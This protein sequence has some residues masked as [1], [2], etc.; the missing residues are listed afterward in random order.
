MPV[1]RS[2]WWLSNIPFCLCTTSS[3]STPLYIFLKIKFVKILNGW[4]L[5]VDDCGCCASESHTG[6]SSAALEVS[7]GLDTGNFKI[8]KAPPFWGPCFAMQALLPSAKVT[9]VTFFF[10]SHTCGTWKFPGQGLNSS[11]SYGSAGSLTHHATAGTPGVTFKE[12]VSS[13][14]FHLAEKGAKTQE[15]QWPA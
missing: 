4:A 11:H 7:E 1:F 8:I 15:S 13:S 10:L 2:F 9:S 12:I 5:E 14:S 3:W 6:G